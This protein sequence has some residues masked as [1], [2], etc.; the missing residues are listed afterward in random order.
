MARKVKE[1]FVHPLDNVASIRGYV[2]QGSHC[3]LLHIPLSVLMIFHQ[4]VH[5]C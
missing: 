2:C 1:K 3:I 4:K 5:M